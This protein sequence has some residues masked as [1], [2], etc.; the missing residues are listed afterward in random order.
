M[1]KFAKPTCS[2]VT[3]LQRPMIYQV[4][5]NGRKA[6]SVVMRAKGCSCKCQ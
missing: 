6:T 2:P 5:Q 3:N 1:D 4:S